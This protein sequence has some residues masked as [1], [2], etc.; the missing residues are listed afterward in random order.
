MVRLRRL[1]RRLAQLHKVPSDC[2]LRDKIARQAPSLQQQ[3]PWLQ[4]LPH[5]GMEGWC[6]WLEDRISELEHRCKASAISAW[7]G[8][9]ESS[10]PQLLAWIQRRE[11]LNIELARPALNADVVR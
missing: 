2:R 3:A 4:E 7:R 11:R 10:E 9:M 6:G 5:F 1:L 8:K